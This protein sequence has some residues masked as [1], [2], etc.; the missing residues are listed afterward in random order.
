VIH[1]KKVFWDCAHN[2]QKVS[3]PF[4]MERNVYEECLE[5]DSW[6]LVFDVPRATYDQ[7]PIYLNGNPDENTFIGKTVKINLNF[8]ILNH[9]PSVVHFAILEFPSK[10]QRNIRASTQKTG[11]TI[12][13]SLYSVG[14]VT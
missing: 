10:F 9:L 6:V 11:G 12:P 13:F 8:H 3:S 1:Y 14:T 4:L 2:Q 5:D 7:K